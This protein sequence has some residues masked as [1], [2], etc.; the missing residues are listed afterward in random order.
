MSSQDDKPYEMPT[1]S[2]SKSEEKKQVADGKEKKLETLKIGERQN[3]KKQSPNP[4]KRVI[5]WGICIIILVFI[6]CAIIG[7][8]SEENEP[9]VYNENNEV[10]I[11]I[12]D[13]IVQS[14]EEWTESSAELDNSIIND[15]L[16]KQ[17]FDYFELMGDNSYV[18]TEIEAVLD[19]VQV[20][21]G[22]YYFCM[23]E[24]FEEFLLIDD[25]KER[26]VQLLQGDVI[27]VNGN[28]VGKQQCE[29]TDGGSDELFIIDAKNIEFLKKVGS[30]LGYFDSMTNGTKK[31][32]EYNADAIKDINGFVNYE[33]MELAGLI[34]C[35]AKK[36][37]PTLNVSDDRWSSNAD[38]YGTY[39]FFTNDTWGK[40]H[41][42]GKVEFVLDDKSV[43]TIV[44]GGR[45]DYNDN[46]MYGI[47]CGDNLFDVQHKIPDEFKLIKEV[48]EEWE[49][50]YFLVYRT[51]KTKDLYFLL[52][53]DYFQASNDHPAVFNIY[54]MILTKDNPK[55]FNEYGGE[56]FDEES[57]ATRQVS[58]KL[59]LPV[60][61]IKGFEK[62]ELNTGRE[63]D[64]EYVLPNSGTSYLSE[65][66]LLK[67]SKEELRIARNEIY[68]RHHSIFIAE[69]MQKYFESK[70]W[71]DGFISPENF[72][73]TNLNEYEKRNLELIKQLE[74]E[75]SIQLDIPKEFDYEEFLLGKWEQSY[76]SSALIVSIDIKQIDN[77]TATF[78][79]NAC[80]NISE[81]NLSEKDIVAQYDPERK[82]I[83]F[84][85]DNVD[86]FLILDK[87]EL[88]SYIHGEVNFHTSFAE[89]N[90]S[91]IEFLK[92]PIF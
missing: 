45:E 27:G 82:K 9:N 2:K 17:S 70:F 13:E 72:D 66:E 38:K 6:I 87:Q 67:L 1:I 19:I 11:E 20:I 26:S 53:G 90:V 24:E 60:N 39:R 81:H 48:I 22:R 8:D 32:S 43:R 76:G 35:S 33:N 86:G 50:N 62:K 21:D 7:E 59:P 91:Q 44:T 3:L 46:L 61:L 83:S 42:S 51:Y 85:T 80:W 23:N 29:W 58:S 25:R 54:K 74:G 64:A 15:K 77:E 47:K 28:Y 10:T 57:E 41:Y 55:K 92:A 34:N 71:Y 49:E 18:G 65:E 68:A 88:E 63:V 4:I 75:D 84:E 36:I 69:D 40:Y 12:S 78:D 5:Y 56:Y 73:E 79:L 16:Y 31:L 30:V 37:I 14:S 52:S 89:Y